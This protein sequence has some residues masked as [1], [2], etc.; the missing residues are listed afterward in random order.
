VAPADDVSPL[1]MTWQARSPTD[2]A[3]W[4]YV[5]GSIADWLSAMPIVAFSFLCHQVPFASHTLT[6]SPIFS[7]LCHRYPLTL[8]SLTTCSFLCHQ[9]A[10]LLPSPS[11][12]HP[13]TMHYPSP[14][15]R[16]TL[17]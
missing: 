12:T 11:L 6:L 3:W 4:V 9:V 8:T 17:S 15:T 13:L 5:D 1:L 14:A 2:A 16:C 10:I 7:F